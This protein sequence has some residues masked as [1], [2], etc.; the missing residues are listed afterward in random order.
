MLSFPFARTSICNAQAPATAP[1]PL[2]S[3]AIIPTTVPTIVPTADS[4]A[5]EL[6]PGQKSGLPYELGLQATLIDQQLFKFTSPYSGKNSL[7]SRNENEKTDTYTVYT[8]VRLFHG[9]DV[10]VNPEMARGNGLSTALGLA[11]FVNGDVVRNPALGMQPYLARYFAR[12]TVATGRGEQKV[13]AAENQIPGMRP[14][15]RLVITAGKLGTN[16]IFD[17]NSYASNTRTQFMNWALINGAAYDYA[18]DTRGYTMGVALEYIQ[19]AWAL[20]LARFQMPTVANGEEMH[21]DMTHFHGDQVEVEFHP[22]LLAHKDPFVLH[23]L[24]FINVAHM[25][26]YAD[27]VALAEQMGGVPSIL[28]T[29]RNSAVKY[30]FGANFEQTLADGGATGLFGRYYWNDGATESYAYTEADRSL[31]FGYQLS[32]A[33]WHRKDD[34]W[35]IAIAQNDISASHKAYL[36]AGGLGFLLGDGKLSYGSEQILETYYNYQVIKPL[37][38]GL[39]Y[40]LVNNPGFNAARGPVSVLSLR[41]HL[42]F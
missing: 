6:H 21:L 39:D 4:T 41:A 32:G 37:T 13:E 42:E 23:L 36:E 25:G 14:T 33:H 22:H 34:R 10:Y 7:L 2:T 11:G 16:D 12:Y 24:S 29:E 1:L 20:R 27:S 9:L 40:Q 19:P 8:G 3:S 5:G 17:V 18:A 30:G 31:S 15:H 35:A 26:N 28:L 38:V